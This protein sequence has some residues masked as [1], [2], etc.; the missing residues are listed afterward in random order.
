MDISI[1]RVEVAIELEEAVELRHEVLGD[2]P[3]WRGQKKRDLC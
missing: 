1:K 2:C 3:T